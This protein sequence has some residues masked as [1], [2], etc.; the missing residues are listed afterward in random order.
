[1]ARTITTE[2]APSAKPVGV[3]KPVTTVWTEMADGPEYDIPRVGFNSGER[4]IAPGVAEVSSPLLISNISDSPISIDV[5]IIRDNGDES[6]LAQSFPVP[7][8]D[9]SI[10]PVQ[11]QFLK[12][13]DIL[14]VRSEQDTGLFA[15]LAYTEGQAEE[16]DVT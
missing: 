5:K 4:R 16:D 3:S 12:S 11:G 10:F 7:F 2:I 15:T 1:M 13:G 6:I 9:I 14:Q 8:G